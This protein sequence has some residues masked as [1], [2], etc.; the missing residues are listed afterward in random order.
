MTTKKRKPHTE[1][2]KRKLSLAKL[3]NKNPMF[4]KR[5]SDETRRK[6]SSAVKGKN[7]Y[8]FG[9]KMSRELKD[10]ISAGRRGLLLADKNHEWKGD[11]VSYSGIHKWIRNN[12]GQPRVCEFCKKDNLTGRKIH[13]ANK[14]G[15]YRRVPSDWLRLCSG[16]HGS[17]DK[18]KGLRK[19][20]KTTI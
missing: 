6:I 14:S 5:V 12:S 16:C 9:K 18:K 1:E 13:W 10:K 11:R 8:F 20:N 19:R 2:T 7:H 3:G 17:Y 4:G 15:L